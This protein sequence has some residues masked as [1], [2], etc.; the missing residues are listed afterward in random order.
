M[1][2]SYIEIVFPWH[3]VI[4]MTFACAIGRSCLFLARMSR[5]M[6]IIQR[7]F[8]IL[9]LNKAGRMKG[10][11]GSGLNGRHEYDVYQYKKAAIAKFAMTSSRRRITEK[12]WMAKCVVGHQRYSKSTLEDCESTFDEGFIATP[13]QIG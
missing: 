8:A 12:S 9:H 10:R 2:L 5:V 7:A 11:R 4:A 3:I 6:L 1:C 13:Y